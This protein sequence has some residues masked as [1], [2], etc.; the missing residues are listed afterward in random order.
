MKTRPKIPYK[1]VSVAGELTTLAKV[2][3]IVMLVTLL[4]LA[5]TGIIAIV[6]AIEYH[7]T[8]IAFPWRNN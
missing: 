1:M 7:P 5:M 4:F 2:V 3:I 6:Y 8:E